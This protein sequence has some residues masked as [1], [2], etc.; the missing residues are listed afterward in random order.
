[1]GGTS[2]DVSLVDGEL[3]QRFEHLIAGA[4]LN[5]PMLD[6]HSIAAGGGSILSYHDGRFA[7]G[8]ASAGA[9]PGPVCYGRGGPLTLT[10]LQVLLGH[11]RTDT[12]PAGFGPE[13]PPP[14]HAPKVNAAFA[15]LAPGVRA[16]G[17]PPRPPEM[18]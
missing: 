4:R 14:L 9:E 10:D 2:T 17:A 12:L 15:P 13:G 11:L 6:V 1:M 16:A 18:L 5:Q 7:V 3:P 8:P